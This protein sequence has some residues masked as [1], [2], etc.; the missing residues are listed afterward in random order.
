MKNRNVIAILFALL[1]AALYAVSTPVSKLLLESVPPTMVA[2]FLYLGAGAGMGLMMLG[3]KGVHRNAE[4]KLSRK[5]FPYALA[6][7]LLDILA[8]ILM[9]YG[10]RM[11]LAANTALLNNFEIVA[12]ALIALLLFREKVSGR[13]WVAI[14]LVTIASILLSLDGAS[15]GEALRFSKGSLLVLGA[16]VCWG[17]ENNCTRQIAGKDPMEIVTVK[18]FGSGAGALVIA[19]CLKEPFPEWKHIG[20]L[21]LLGFVAYGLSIYF[22][23]LSQRSIGAA[24]TSAYYAVA[25]FIGALL[26]FVFLQEPLTAVYAVALVIMLAGAALVVVDTLVHSHTHLHYHT[27]THTHDGSTHTHTVAHSH[28]HKHYLT[29]DAHGHHHSEEELM[30][31]HKNN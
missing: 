22:Y 9:M 25:P 29:D 19:L 15:I 27:F 12:T 31:M 26:S 6:M 30:A 16:T 8:P 1:A 5:D 2:A 4:E 18:G 20:I 11:N 24:K 28:D 10:L 17:L 7:V 3:R 23:T 21:L 14:G 13:L